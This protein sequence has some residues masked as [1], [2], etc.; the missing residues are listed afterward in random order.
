LLVIILI[1]TGLT[2]W[3]VIKLKRRHLNKVW[4]KN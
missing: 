1:L 3:L 4:V 2:W